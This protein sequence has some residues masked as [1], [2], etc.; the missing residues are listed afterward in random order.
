[1]ACSVR[2]DSTLSTVHCVTFNARSICNKLSELHLLLSENPGLVCITETW[3]NPSITNNL[4]TDNFNYSVY[5]RDRPDRHGGGVCI[6]INN[7]IFDS[8]AV[9][10]PA[11]YN[12]LELIAVNIL[13]LP[14]KCR[15]VAI[16]RQPTC[17]S[18][19]SGC[20][21]C[22]DIS[23]CID[24]LYCNNTAMIICGDFNLPSYDTQSQS[25][26]DFSCSHILS[27]IFS[28]YAFTQY[29]TEPTR[30]GNGQNAS[31]L[32]F[33]LCN[34]TNLLLNIAVSCPFGNSDH[35]VISFDIF[36]NNNSV[37]QKIINN[38]STYDFKRADWSVIFAYLNNVDF[39][40]DF[41]YFDS[42]DECFA[43]F[44][45]V[46]NDCIVSHVPCVTS[47]I[48][49][50][51][52]HYPAAIK[53]H[54][55]LKK[56]SWK[57]YKKVRTA[58]TLKHYKHRA[59][60]YRT[61]IQQYNAIRENRIVNSSNI[62]AFYRYCNRKFSCR[63]IIGPLATSDGQYIC[64]SRTKTYI[65]RES[66]S[67]NYITDN[68]ITPAVTRP[69]T[70]QFDTIYFTTS[71]VNKAIK[72]LR[73]KS[74]GGPD[75]IPPIFIKKCSL[76]LAPVLA[77]LFDYSFRQSYIPPVWKSA[78]VT[79]VYKKGDRTNPSNYRPISL[80]CVLCKV[81]E[82]IIK[83]QLTAYLHTN[84]IITD[85]Q[86]AFI[87]QHSTVTNLLECT[88]DWSLAISNKHFVDVI[89]IDFRRA[90]DSIVHSK[91]LIKLRSYGI[92]GNLLSWISSFLSNRFQ[93][94]VVDN[95]YSNEFPVTSG[96]I[97][98]SV[99]GPILFILFINDLSDVIRHNAHI[100]LVLFADDL[101]LFSEFLLDTS[102][103]PLSI[104]DLQLVLNNVF[105]WSTIWQLPIN[106]DKCSSARLFS[107]SILNPVY[108]INGLPITHLDS[109]RD[110]GIEIDS[111]LSYNNHINS[112]VSKAN[113]RVGLLFRGF[114]CRNLDFMR[115]AFIA[116]I[117]PI[118]EYNSVVWNPTLKK[119]IDSLEKI[120]RRFTKKIPSISHLPY[121]ER[122]SAINLQS[123]ELRRLHF[124][125]VHYYKIL[126][127]LTPH[128]PADFFT[129]HYPPPS[130]RNT[131]PIL[132][133]P[134][135]GT[136]VLFSSFCCRAVNS[137]NHIP[138]H[139]QKLNSLPQF[140]KALNSIDFTSFLY[141]SSYT[142]MVNF[143]CLP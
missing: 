52:A 114:Q 30:Y 87:K 121:L 103:I 7:D 28:N 37:C 79:P 97:Q 124:D 64:D 128:K 60:V 88:H 33:V 58:A 62:T 90:F 22:Q 140:K 119:H 1:M 126:H 86:H 9:N 85:H 49:N 93:Q 14:Y 4:L 35:C 48:G 143:S 2:T 51:K 25:H 117:R 134:R 68:Y 20:L 54:L 135:S 43:Y 55:S 42:A 110:L 15:L 92:S 101:K 107:R 112:I 78:L 75:N 41:A 27:E 5:R 26:N 122:L 6:L 98:G 118:V 72:R 81:M 129:Y 8:C 63:S 104:V 139:I 108:T 106:I 142:N 125:L 141:G 11:S 138:H 57:A 132:I 69:L 3:L 40:R 34:D 32:D 94:V 23:D 24:H 99:L 120:Q 36:H 13:N 73:P 84:N 76:W 95:C 115:K 45:N 39:L 74:K 21:N 53:R 56:S 82:S 38:R 65:F 80:T 127:N 10:I 100:T 102:N 18:D 133:N 70:S 19:I 91:L 71:L 17:D 131:K 66:F 61:S 31:L 109:T 83:D 96:I 89:Y 105:L 136:K 111:R 50:K 77:Y 29:V 137:W 113:Q 116:Y 16:Y 67:S 46:I 123:L 44:Y 12:H 47:N 59:F 130:S